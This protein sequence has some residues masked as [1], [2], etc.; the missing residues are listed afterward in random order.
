M[1]QFFQFQILVISFAMVTGCSSMG[2]KWKAFLNEG[3]ETPVANSKPMDGNVKFSDTK[4]LP[5]DGARQYKRMTKKQFEDQ[6]LFSDNAGSLW[7]NE[8]QDSYLF[9]QNIVRLPGD[10]LNVILDGQPEKQ[11]STKAKVIQELTNRIEKAQRGVAS[12]PTTADG[13]PVDPNAK[14][15]D[16]NAPPAVGP[17]GKPLDPNAKPVDPNA[18]AAAAPVQKPVEEPMP[19]IENFDVKTIPTRI[20]ERLSD[21]NYRVKGAQTFMIGAKEYKV[22]VTGLVKPADV[23]DDNVSSSK[24][25]ESKFDIV[26]Y[27]KGKVF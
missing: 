12:V 24:M 23:A 14:P 15:V 22:I 1:K 19:G 17:D 2:K 9:A 13:K 6:E 3:Q 5:V 26:R 16:P 25:L 11:L 7:V 4:D 27:N 20:V 21:G 10:I 18:V 8:G